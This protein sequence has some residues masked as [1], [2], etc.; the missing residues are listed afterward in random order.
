MRAKPMKQC[1][2][3]WNK[4]PIT[5]FARSLFG[6]L[7]A[8]SDQLFL[9][10]DIFPPQDLVRGIFSDQFTA[11]E[12]GETR[13]SKKRD[14]FRQLFFCRRQKLFKLCRLQ[15]FRILETVR[16]LSRGSLCFASLSA[17]KYGTPYFSARK[18]DCKI[19]LLW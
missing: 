15:N 1:S 12:A 16:P 5:H 7:V 2:F 17:K 19:S 11:P 3:H 9:P 8:D 4:A 18:A 10:V 13:H 14:Q 6:N